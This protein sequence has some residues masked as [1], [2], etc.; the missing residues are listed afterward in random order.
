M[1]CVRAEK[2]RERADYIL[3]NRRDLNEFEGVTDSVEVLK[4]IH[5]SRPFDPMINWIPYPQATSRIYAEL[6]D[7]EQQRVAEYA[8]S[9]IGSDR[10]NEAEEIVL[11][12]AAFTDASLEAC[13]WAFLQHRSYLPS[14]SFRQA[15]AE[16]RD[17]LVERLDREE[18][19]RDHLLRAL[20]WIGDSTIV[21][22]FDLWRKSPPLW[23]NSL[24]VSPSAY[25]YEAGWEITADGKRRDL[26]F[27]NC[28]KLV[29]GNSQSPQEFR[30]ILPRTDRCAWCRQTLTN[31]LD[32]NLS[33]FVRWGD[34]RT[35]RLQVLTCESCTGFGTIFG[36]LDESGE[37]RW[38]DA[39]VRPAYLPHNSE[40]WERLPQ[41]SLD[42]AGGRSPLAAANQFLPT[43][44]S[45]IGG[46]P[47][48]I[49]DANYPQ[50]PI[51][52]E[53]MMFLAQVDLADLEDCSEGIIYSFICYDCKTAATNYQQS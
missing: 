20:V 7:H 27:Q 24:Y 5:R 39:N 45:Q 25:S 19:N 22:L 1:P 29:R 49:Q 31:L 44:F 42:L 26:Y 8:E 48:W 34:S 14:L 21:E 40:D 11:C 36:V 18:E 33:D 28:T 4:I 38:S 17:E 41:N 12:L 47:A 3:K 23:S 30:A 53:T 32:L 35:E 2:E 46:H 16:I 37:Y 10:N 43:T 9:L 51:C 52:Q 50:C 15:S 6:T 13:L